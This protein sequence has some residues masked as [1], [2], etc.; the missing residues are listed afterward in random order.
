[1]ANPTVVS[2]ADAHVPS[3][4]IRPVRRLRICLVI[5]VDPQHPFD[6][7]DH[8]ADGATDNCA[9]RACSPTALVDAMRNSTRYTLRL[10]NNGHRN[11]YQHACK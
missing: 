10:R 2:R 5:A 1:M 6:A 4:S 11:R 8:A 3:M 7:A 9:H